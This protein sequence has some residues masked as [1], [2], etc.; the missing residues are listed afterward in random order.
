MIEDYKAFKITIDFLQKDKDEYHTKLNG[1]VEFCN[2][3]AKDMPWKLR[4]AM[5]ELDK[6]NTHPSVVSFILLYKEML[7]R[8]IMS[9]KN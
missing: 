2:L 1:L 8:F 7:R 3:S 9:W 5:E 6:G 4:D